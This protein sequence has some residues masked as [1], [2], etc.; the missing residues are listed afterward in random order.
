VRP[1]VGA[2]GP[3]SAEATASAAGLSQQLADPLHVA[4]RT[5]GRYL[6]EVMLALATL[7]AAL[8][9]IAARREIKRRRSQRAP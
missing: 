7:A 4:A 2:P 6:I 5:P 1:A 9:G 8:I 3:H